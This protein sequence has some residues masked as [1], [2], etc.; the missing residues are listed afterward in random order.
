MGMGSI[1]G[2]GPGTETGAYHDQEVRKSNLQASTTSSMLTSFL[3]MLLEDCKAF[4]EMF[5]MTYM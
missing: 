3:A 5:I 1:K 4:L 2:E